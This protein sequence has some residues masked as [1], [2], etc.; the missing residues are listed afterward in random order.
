MTFNMGSQSINSMFREAVIAAACALC[1]GCF[2]PIGQGYWTEGE[3][4]AETFTAKAEKEQALV[5]ELT[6][7]NHKVD[8]VYAE[9]C[10]AITR[11]S[12]LWGQDVD[13]VHVTRQEM[14]GMHFSVKAKREQS[15]AA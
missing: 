14:I 15:I 10:D 2:V 4:R 5:I 3:T 12:T 8:R 1:G 9:M 11:L 13:W 7:E 6:C